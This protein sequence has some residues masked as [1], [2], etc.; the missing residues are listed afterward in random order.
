MND[1]IEMIYLF[2]FSTFLSWN[3]ILKNYFISL[4]IFIVGIFIFLTKSLYFPKI[5]SFKKDKIVD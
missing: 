2:I 5:E 3:I 1:L 4:F